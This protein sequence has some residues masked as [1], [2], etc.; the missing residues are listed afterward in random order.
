M[1]IIISI[2]LCKPI[3]VIFN[4]VALAIGIANV[5]LTTRINKLTNGGLAMQERGF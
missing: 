4:D 2:Y 3:Q 5:A 1:N